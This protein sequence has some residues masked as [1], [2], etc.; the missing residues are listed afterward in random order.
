VKILGVLGVVDAG[1]VGGWE[2]IVAI[3]GLENR[4]EDRNKTYTIEGKSLL[5]RNL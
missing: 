3:S 2:A 4:D 5:W 1:V